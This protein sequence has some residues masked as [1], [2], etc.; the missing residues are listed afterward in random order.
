MG[1]G[2]LGCIDGGPVLGVGRAFQ[3]PPGRGQNRRISQTD[4][5]PPDQKLRPAQTVNQCNSGKTEKGDNQH[6]STTNHHRA[7]RSV[8]QKP[9]KKQGRQHGAAAK[10]AECQGHVG[11]R[12]PQIGAH[13][14]NGVD[15]NHRPGGRCGKVQ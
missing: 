9:W 5:E 12:Q 8:V 7:V 15:Q 6:A 3:Q 11:I 4:D 13:Q 14:H 10:C 2:E 1:Q